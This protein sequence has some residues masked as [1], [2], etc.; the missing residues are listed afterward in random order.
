VAPET[1]TLLV[2]G[3][4]LEARGVIEVRGKGRMPTGYLIGRKD[5]RH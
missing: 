4:T 5:G 2:D 3:F 1:Y